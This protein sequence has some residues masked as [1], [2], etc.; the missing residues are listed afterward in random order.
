MQACYNVFERFGYAEAPRPN[1]HFERGPLMETKKPAP[2][3]PAV[4]IAAAAVCLLALIALF[5]LRPFKEN[6]QT[7]CIHADAL[8]PGDSEAFPLSLPRSFVGR[9]SLQAQAGSE[10]API[11]RSVCI[12]VRDADDTVLYD[13]LIDAMPTLRLPAGDCLISLSLPT[14]VG[15]DCTLSDFSLTFA[16]RDPTANIIWYCLLFLLTASDVAL[17]VSLCRANRP[18]GSGNIS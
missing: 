18:R 11:L 7:L 17:F 9:L 12:T 5:L 3:R 10:D 2:V 15:N 14:S 1:P 6:A 16:L 13:G 4:A 8:L